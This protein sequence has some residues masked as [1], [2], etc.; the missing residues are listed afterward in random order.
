MEADLVIVEEDPWE[1]D[2]QKVEQ[3]PG[4]Y[5]AFEPMDS[6]ESYRMMEDFI[7]QLD[8]DKLAQRLLQAI[9]KKRPFAHFKNEI[10]HSGP[11][12]DKWFEFRDQHYINW[13]RRE[14][15]MQLD[16]SEE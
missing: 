1:E 5:L 16:E 7:N 15:E 8:D 13:T 6:H 2:R 12:R 3:D 9:E 14:W 4:K 11:Y 10:D